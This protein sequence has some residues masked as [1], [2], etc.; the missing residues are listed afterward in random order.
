MILIIYLKGLSKTWKINSED[1]NYMKY[2]NNKIR[3]NTFIDLYLDK[4]SKINLS[5]Y[6][7]TIQTINKNNINTDLSLIKNFETNLSN[8]SNKNQ[9]FNYYRN[10]GSSY[11][12]GC[13][14]RRNV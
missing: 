12:Y 5:N 14:R 7:T 13:L 11:D 8:H 6:N 10:N 4:E 2:H 9:Y 1:S 3:T